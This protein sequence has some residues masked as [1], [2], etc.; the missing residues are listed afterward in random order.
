MG[1][2]VTKGGIEFQV[3]D[4]FRPIA[5]LQRYCLDTGSDPKDVDI[6]VL[7]KDLRGSDLSG[8]KSGFHFV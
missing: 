1:T 6:N 8:Q 3:K 2:D 4:K 7:A 5:K